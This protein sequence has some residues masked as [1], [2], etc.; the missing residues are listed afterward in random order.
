MKKIDH[1]SFVEQLSSRASGCRTCKD[2]SLP[3][4][5]EV[6]EAVL[7]A[8]K[9]GEASIPK[10]CDYMEKISPGWKKRVGPYSLKQHLRDHE[11]EW[12]KARSK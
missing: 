3:V 4:L 10:L 12:S 6:L 7:K 11:P 9:A 1:S 2:V 8:N 5:R